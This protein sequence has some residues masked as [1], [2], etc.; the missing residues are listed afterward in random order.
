VYLVADTSGIGGT[1]M[2]GDAVSAV[3]AEGG[4]AEPVDGEVD[5]VVP[6]ADPMIALVAIRASKRFRR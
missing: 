3:P 1:V 2:A 6:H 4:A 5:A